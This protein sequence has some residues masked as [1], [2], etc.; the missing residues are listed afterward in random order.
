MIIS[1]CRQLHSPTNILLLSLA[2]SDFLV[3]SLVLPAEVLK[4]A[5]CWLLGDLMCAAYFF[6]PFIVIAGSVLNVVFI[7]VDRFVAICYPLHY[8]TRFTTKGAVVTV[9]LGWMYTVFHSSVLLFDHL[10]QP[11]RYNS[12]YGECMVNIAGDMDIVG[13]IIPISII[14]ILYMRVFVVAASQARAMRSQVAASTTKKSELKAARNLGVLVLVFLIC[15]CPYYCV[16][17]SGDKIEVGSSAEIYMACLLYFN[18]CL[19][20]I[21]YAMLYPW[22]RK[23]LRLIVTLQ[24]LQPDSC[25]A[26]MS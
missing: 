20:P 12:C 25:D 19:N 5:T 16:S 4:T 14:V 22:F 23:A 8:P 7:S 2:V 21:I 10:K 9:C 17:L 15:Y 18:S 11:G 3:G 1:P 6:L 26:N 13:F 24:I